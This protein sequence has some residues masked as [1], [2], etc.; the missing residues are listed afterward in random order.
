V[1]LLG[2]LATAGHATAFQLT[3][4]YVLEV[5]GWAPW[6]YSTMFFFCGAVGIV[7][8]PLAGRLGDLYG[9][10]AVARVVLGLFPLA[11]F[12]FYTGPGWAVPFGWIAMVFMSMSAGVVVR[13]LANEVFP[14]SHRGTGGGLL[15]SVET[16]G[17]AGGLFLYALLQ[18]LYQN[19]GMVVAG[20]SLL[21]VV[22][23]TALVLFPETRA[24][25]LEVISA[26]SE[27]AAA[28]RR[29]AP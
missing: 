8:S 14:T 26:E 23:V 22:S 2:T 24:L 10:R 12:T 4:Y 3:A 28:R 27:R 15:S 13:A 11:A 9:R 19:Q 25:E 21:T 7:G 18:E 5:H 1:I 6:Q 29:S 17:G 20:L 16:L